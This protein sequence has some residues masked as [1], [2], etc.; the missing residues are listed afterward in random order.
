[1]ATINIS[2]E[3]FLATRKFYDDRNYP[4][5]MS[6]S[7]DF[8]LSEVQIIETHGVA[9][10]AL[11]TKS[12]IP[13]NDEEKHFI[14]VCEGKADANTSIEKAWKKYQNKVLSPKHFH[15]LFGRTKVDVE[16]DSSSTNTDSDSI[17]LDIDE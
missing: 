4:R 2:K 17:G 10:Q 12:Q 6:R 1:M 15:T 14:L 13:I 3:S 11:M 7:G 9:L 8:T 5:G 16:D